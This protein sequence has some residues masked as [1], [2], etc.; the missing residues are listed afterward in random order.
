[1]RLLF[2]DYCRRRS[3]NRPVARDVFPLDL[4]AQRELVFASRRI[5]SRIADL[6]CSICLVSCS[7][8]AP[9][10]ER[11]PRRQ[12]RRDSSSSVSFGAN[13]VSAVSDVDRSTSFASL[14]PR[15][16]ERRG[17]LSDLSSCSLANCCRL[18]RL[19]PPRLHYHL[20]PFLRRQIVLFRFWSP[21]LSV[22]SRETSSR[23]NCASP[24]LP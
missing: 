23:R 19:H 13:S 11:F 4:D 6:F 5:N 17:L 15:S 18:G 21:G 22:R 7:A 2:L 9:A 10:A 24:S 20:Q 8:R 3:P 1:V 12:C 14:S 16:L